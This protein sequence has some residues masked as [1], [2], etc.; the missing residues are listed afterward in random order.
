[1]W[2]SLVGDRII[3]STAMIVSLSQHTWL[4]NKLRRYTVSKMLKL[5]FY[6]S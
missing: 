2:I 3:G 5:L 1:M 6:Y 4:V